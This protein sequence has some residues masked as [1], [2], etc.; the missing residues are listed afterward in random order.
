MKLGQNPVI[1]ALQRADGVK[2]GRP[3]T[4]SLD[5]GA[6]IGKRGKVCAG[7]KVWSSVSDPIILSVCLSNQVYGGSGRT[8]LELHA[9]E[10]AALFKTMPKRVAW[11][12]P[13]CMCCW[14]RTSS[15]R[16]SARGDLHVTY[17]DELRRTTWKSWF[18]GHICLA[19]IM[20]VS[21]KKECA[22]NR[23]PGITVLTR[24]TLLF[25]DRRPASF[26]SQFMI[27]SPLIAIVSL[28]DAVPTARRSSC[29]SINGQSRLEPRMVATFCGTSSTRR[30]ATMVRP[31]DSTNNQVGSMR[32]ITINTELRYTD[33]LR[34]TYC[35]CSR[36]FPRA[37]YFSLQ[38]HL[39]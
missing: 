1:E 2:R 23:F 36:I 29:S 20:A 16:N 30:I 10:R 22:S 6:R 38:I 28:A 25:H 5:R 9:E 7:R 35:K 13:G 33:R 12:V 11:P 26:E 14:C 4:T 21:S 37:T 24:F 34:C 15:S 19:R 3:G 31:G 18:N 8:M 39:S 32:S 27:L 17:T